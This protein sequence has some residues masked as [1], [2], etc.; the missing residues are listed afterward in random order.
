MQVTFDPIKRAKTLVD[1][2]LDFADAIFVFEGSLWRLKMTA[3]TM[4]R[5]ESFALVSWPNGWS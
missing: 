4:E 3:K 5:F 2:G 1:R